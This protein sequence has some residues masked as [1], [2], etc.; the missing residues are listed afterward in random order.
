MKLV[1]GL[2]AASLA[3]AAAVV[4]YVLLAPGGSGGS[5]SALIP[6]HTPSPVVPTATPLPSSWP[7]GLWTAKGGRPVLLSCQDRNGDGR[8]DGADGDQ[9]A[10][11]DIAL[12]PGQACIDPAHRADYYA[13]PPSDPAG[14][15]C[16]APRPPALLVVVASAGSNL[17][18]PSSG[19]SM[20]VLA[21]AGALQ[22]RAA[23]ARMATETILATSAVFGARMPQTSMEGWLRQ[24]IS[25]RLAAMPC[26][27]AVIIGHSHGGVIVTSVAAALDGQDASRLFGV[28]LDRTTALYDRGA[29]E[30]PARTALLN[31]YQLNEGWHGVAI[32]RPN[33]TNVDASGALAPIAPSDGR[34]GPA[35]VTHKTL[36]DAPDVQRRVE[37]AV[38]AWL[39]AAAR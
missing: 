19:E 25:R 28:I 35:L 33:I 20:G 11:V 23:D 8:L 18:D 7:A 1:A 30:M 13:G 39:G 4:L 21:M 26:L 9:F 3:I 29:E 24:E 16:D 36:D 15:S 12:A 5:V 6:T 10:G 38:M 32:D 2:G 17:L 27:R 14:Y 34:G 37:D 31:I 22:R